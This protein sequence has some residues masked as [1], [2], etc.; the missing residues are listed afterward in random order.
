M[1]EERKIVDLVARLKAK[2]VRNE[3]NYIA[4]LRP[5]PEIYS[6]LTPVIGAMRDKGLSFQEIAETMRF[7]AE[8]LDSEKV[9]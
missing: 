7:V 2:A 1:S 3:K 6:L 4:K 9:E 8:V 5:F